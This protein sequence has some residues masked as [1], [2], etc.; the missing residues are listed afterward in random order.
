MSFQ[1]P[2]KILKCV[3]ETKIFEMAIN[4]YVLNIAQETGDFLWIR[5]H[6]EEI[7]L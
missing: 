3:S 1:F 5:I 4:I 2:H 7:W 6:I